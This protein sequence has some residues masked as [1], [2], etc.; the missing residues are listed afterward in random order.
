MHW[1]DRY[2]GGFHGLLLQVLTLLVP[3]TTLLRVKLRDKFGHQKNR[4]SVIPRSI[5]YLLVQFALVVC[6]TL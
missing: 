2:T 1:I 4:I 6:F 5:P 3:Y